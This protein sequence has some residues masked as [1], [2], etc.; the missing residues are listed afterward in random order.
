[1]VS[2]NLPKHWVTSAMPKLDSWG[3]RGSGRQF[4]SSWSISELPQV[5]LHP[6]EV[7]SYPEKM[8]SHRRWWA[9][10]RYPPTRWWKLGETNPT[11]YPSIYL[12]GIITKQKEDLF[13]KI[14]GSIKV[15]SEKVK[16]SLCIVILSCRGSVTTLDFHNQLLLY[17]SHSLREQHLIGMKRG[18]E[19]GLELYHGDGLGS[20]SSYTRA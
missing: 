17:T 12:H 5:D 9:L 14:K 2:D 20:S 16:H 7:C 6:R 10:T 4:T 15:V 13:R 19:Q 11:P 8:G 1:M 3:S 18:R